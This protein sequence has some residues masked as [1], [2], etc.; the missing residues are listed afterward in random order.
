[1]LSI[2]TGGKK[3]ALP[4]RE[5]GKPSVLRGA[6]VRQRCCRC[7][8]ITQRAPGACVRPCSRPPDTG[9]RVY[10]S[11]RIRENVHTSAGYVQVRD[12]AA[13]V[14]PG[15][16]PAIFK[17]KALQHTCPELTWDADDPDRAKAL[18]LAAAAP[19]A[20][21]APK[22]GKR[23]GKPTAEDLQEDNLRAYLASD[24]GSGSDG[25][26]SD[27]EAAAEAL[28]AQCAPALSRRTADPCVL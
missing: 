7:A 18:A 9:V 23:G 4:N 14:P 1:M 17:S 27:G 12:R 2:H 3:C 13:G 11:Y 15:Y 22:G 5:W 26:G 6:R 24:S 10:V 20:F 28:R 16:E 19:A 21:K 25:S 8:D